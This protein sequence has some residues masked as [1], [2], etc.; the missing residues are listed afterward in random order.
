[1]LKRV[2]SG[3]LRQVH[4]AG[5]THRDLTPNNVMLTDDGVRLIDF[6]IARVADQINPTR[7]GG[8]AG[9]RGFMAPEQRRGGDVTAKADMYALGALLC[10]VATKTW[11]CD[12]PEVAP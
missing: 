6:G 12:T 9:T 1:M 10:Y 2:V 8:S 3:H 11:P 5:I 4:R 7:T